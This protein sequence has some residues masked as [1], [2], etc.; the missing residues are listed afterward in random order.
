MDTDPAEQGPLPASPEA[1][2]FN[3]SNPWRTAALAAERIN[4]AAIAEASPP[5]E[6]LAKLPGWLWIA[7][8]TAASEVLDLPFGTIR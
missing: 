2:R 4:I 1:R 5:A 3:K 8:L 6:L 7:A